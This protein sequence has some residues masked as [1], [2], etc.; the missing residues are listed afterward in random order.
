VEL[1]TQLDANVLHISVTI[2]DRNSQNKL[3]IS[4]TLILLVTVQLKPNHKWELVSLN[5]LVY[6]RFII[7]TDGLLFAPQMRGEARVS[8]TVTVTLT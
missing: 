5:L 2:K 7:A 8:V 1:V 4:V 6:S 3:V